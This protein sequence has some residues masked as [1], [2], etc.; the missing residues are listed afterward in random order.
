MKETKRSH[1]SVD[2]TDA[3]LKAYEQAL[4]LETALQF[5][6]FRMDDE[7]MAPEASVGKKRKKENR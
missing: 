1:A 6:Q 3:Y 2:D 4:S 7:E 5:E